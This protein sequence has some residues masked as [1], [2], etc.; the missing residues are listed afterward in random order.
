[1]VDARGIPLVAAGGRR[2][3]LGQDLGG[4]L[5]GQPVAVH[6]DA[7]VDARIVGKAED[8]G[9]GHGAAVDGDDHARGREHS[10]SRSQRELGRQGQLEGDDPGLAVVFGVDAEQ[11]LALFLQDAHD[12]ALGPALQSFGLEEDLDF[13]AVDRAPGKAGRNEDVA[14]LPARGHDET[15]APA[16]RL[17]AAPDDVGFEG[18]KISR[19]NATDQA[20]ALHVPQMALDPAALFARG[21]E[22]AEDLLQ[23][24][25][26]PLAP[27]RLEDSILKIHERF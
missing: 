5:G 21:A 17:E 11:L 12:A 4:K 6:D 14:R 16:G 9:E 22:L 26:Q 10:R 3:G 19:F 20:S 25:P 18:Q 8:V 13:V 23:S 1:M 7:G 27:E 2:F 15:E 24:K